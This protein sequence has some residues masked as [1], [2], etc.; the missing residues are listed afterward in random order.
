[1]SRQDCLDYRNACF[2]YLNS[3][4]I[5]PSSEEVSDFSMRSLVFSHYAPYQ[6]MMS[7]PDSPRLGIPVPLFN[8]VYHDCLIIPWYMDEPLGKEDYMLYA[9]LN[10]GAA[11][12]DKDGAFFDDAYE[13]ELDHKIER[14]H[15]VS[16]LQEKVAKEEMISH[17]FVDH[18]WYL[19]RTTFASGISVEV[20]LKTNQYHIIYPDHLK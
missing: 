8:L 17:Q 11:Y 10:G 5:L 2:H 6:F 14:Y 18:C 20:N 15:I 4:N 13:K 3:I 1:M 7:A 12:L 9:L 19:Q 16:S